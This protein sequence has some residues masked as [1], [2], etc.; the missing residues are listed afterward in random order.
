MGKGRA[1]VVRQNTTKQLG[2]FCFYRTNSYIRFMPKQ[3]NTD[4]C[5]NNV[6]GGGFCK[7]HQ[8]HRTDKKPK[9]INPVSE[10]LAANLKVYKTVREEFL[11]RHP[12]CQ[13]KI[14]GCTKEAVQI[15]HKKGRIGEL[16]TDNRYFLA[17]CHNCHH[18]IE[19]NP[20]EAKQNGWSLDRY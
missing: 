8:G 9:R 17:V 7:W 18:H 2:G 19:L 16:L 6:F 15:H 10:K 13:A 1:I 12:I 4:G 3:C 5:S 14:S 11:A 20:V